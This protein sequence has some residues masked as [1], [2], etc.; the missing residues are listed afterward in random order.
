MS[1]LWL[2]VGAVLAVAAYSFGIQNSAS[3]DLIFFGV[4][5]FGVPLWLLLLVFT[6][7]GMALGIL[8]TL[9][10]ALRG[11]MQRRRLARQGLDQERTIGQLQQRV[12][13]LERDLSVARS[14]PALPAEDTTRPLTEVPDVS[15]EAPRGRLHAA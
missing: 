10:P 9:P 3:V 15:S 5:F 13:E 7:G 2:I 12:A 14:T 4:R 8:L 1:L 11:A 6:L